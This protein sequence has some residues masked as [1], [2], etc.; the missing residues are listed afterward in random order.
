MGGNEIMIAGMAG[1]V[2]QFVLKSWSENLSIPSTN[3]TLHA[4]PPKQL[5]ENST[6]EIY[7]VRFHGYATHSGVA[8]SARTDA[9]L[10]PLNFLIL[11]FRSLPS[12]LFN[13]KKPLAQRTPRSF[14]LGLSCDLCT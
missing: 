9:L 3:P 2:G 14:V 13:E 1:V 10:A 7:G 6:P 8:A 4:Q 12:W 11:F 5:D